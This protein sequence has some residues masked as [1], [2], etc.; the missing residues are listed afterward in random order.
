MK[1][2]LCPNSERDTHIPNN[3]IPTKI[4][5]IT[6]IVQIKSLVFYV[7]VPDFLHSALELVPTCAS[8]LLPMPLLWSSSLHRQNQAPLSILLTLSLYVSDLPILYQWEL[9]L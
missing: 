4:P 3:N 9:G 8:F 1:T 7:C 2:T 6:A 5:K